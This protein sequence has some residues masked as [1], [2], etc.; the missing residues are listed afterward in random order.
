MEGAGQT[1][2][3]ADCVSLVAE[4]DEMDTKSTIIRRRNCPRNRSD[5]R[6]DATRRGRPLRHCTS[7]CRP[8]ARPP[9]RAGQQSKALGPRRPSDRPPTGSVCRRRRHEAGNYRRPSCVVVAARRT[10]Q[11]RAAVSSRRSRLSAAL[12]SFVLLYLVC[13]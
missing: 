10:R 4:R 7:R 12:T 13:L 8:P 2:R 3:S 1:D 5:A 9:R 6:R 11:T